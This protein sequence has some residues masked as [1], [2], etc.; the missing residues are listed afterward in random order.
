MTL[1]AQSVGFM[2]RA[3]QLARKGWGLTHPNPIVGA[4][5]VEK[6]VV[7]AEGWHRKA[8]QPHAEVEALRALGRKPA[9]DAI[10]YVTM[11]PCSTCG[12]TGACTTAI[13]ESGIKQ[14]VVGC[15]DPNPQHAGH[16]LDILRSNGVHVTEGVLADDCLD[17]N[18][19]FNH[20]ILHKQPLIAM[21]VALTLD[22]KFAAASGHSR[23]VTGEAA[24]E[25]VML[26]R[27]YF[28][29]I[30]V[31]ADTVLEDDP[32]LTSRI[33]S[34]TWC[35]QRFVLDRCLKTVKKGFLPKVY[36]DVYKDRTIVVCSET[37]SEA[38][39]E[40]CE[41]LRELGITIW[42]LPEAG[43]HID[44]VAFRK[45][46]AETFVFGLYFEPGINLASSLLAQQF[47]DYAFVYKA[48]KLL[49]DSEALSM[50]VSRSTQTMS[51]AFRFKHAH[52]NVL[53]EDV[54]FRGYVNFPEK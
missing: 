44:L 22:G 47:V 33:G 40:A 12:Q 24:R 11:E 18:L 28:P 15:R 34:D 42:E 2:Q 54:L 23:W 39:K 19:I 1:D 41:K 29:G 30:V 4:V 8:G 43:G 46:C 7:V 21:K 13:L 32:R 35:P 50:G 3:I 20:W 31:S 5:I 25:D 49:N 36:S 26:W 9:D 38:K 27:R 51:E 17:L 16:G 37:E 52:T 45:Q 48:P 10:F 6:D 53:G 14:L